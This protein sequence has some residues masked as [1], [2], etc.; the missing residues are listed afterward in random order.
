M[1]KEGKFIPD[2]FYFV[3][4][5]RIVNGNDIEMVWRGK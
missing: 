2:V 1:K 3:R 4:K 5:G